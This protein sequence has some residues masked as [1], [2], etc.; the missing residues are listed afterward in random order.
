MKTFFA[1]ALAHPCIFLPVRI[2]GA[3]RRALPCR[4][5]TKT[6]GEARAGDAIQTQGVVSIF[7]R[8]AYAIYRVRLLVS[9]HAFDPRRSKIGPFPAPLIYRSSG[10][11]MPSRAYRLCKRPLLPFLLW[12]RVPR[13]TGFRSININIK[14]HLPYHTQDKNTPP[15]GSNFLD[16]FLQGKRGRHTQRTGW[17]WKHLVRDICIRFIARRIQYALPLVETPSI[18]NRPRGCVILSP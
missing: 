18:E 3:P 10:R 8:D 14:T 4:L 1:R 5:E 11:F 17:L 15:P 16:E 13:G 2:R 9:L 6:R 12:R 7:S